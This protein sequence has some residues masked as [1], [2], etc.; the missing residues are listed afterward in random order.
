MREKIVTS[1]NMRDMEYDHCGSE[2]WS[3]NKIEKELVD[4]NGKKVKIEPSDEGDE[5]IEKRDEIFGI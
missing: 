4:K 3:R 1:K 2:I 5:E